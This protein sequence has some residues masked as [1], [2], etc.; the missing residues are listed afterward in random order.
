MQLLVLGHSHHYETANLCRVFF[1]LDPVKIFYEEAAADGGRRVVTRVSNGA[2][3]RFFVSVSDESGETVR[4]APCT[5]GDEEHALAAL[6]YTALAAHT[7]KSPKWGM[8]TGIHPIKLLRQYTREFGEAEGAARFQRENFVSAEKTA[9]ARETLCAEK[10][11]LEDIGENDFSLYI[12][13]PFCPTRCAYC[14]FVSQSVEQAKRQIPEYHALLLREIEETASVARALSLRLRTVYIGG[15]TPTTLSAKALLSLIQTVRGA[16][17]LSACTEFT[18]EAGRP[19]TID[20]EKLQALRAGGVTRISINPQTLDDRVLQAIGRRHTAEETVQAF[21]LAREEGFRNINMDLIV[22]LPEDT[23]ERFCS[24]IDRVLELDPESVTVHALA[25]KRSSGITKQG[26]TAAHGDTDL[27]DRMMAYAQRR[28]TAHGH[29][30]YY[31]Y[32][33]SRM[34]GNLENTGWAKPGFACAYNIYTMDE[35]ETVLAC[36]AGGVSKL[37]DPYSNNLERIFNFKY[38]YE[39]IS[40]YEEILK[41]KGGIEKHYE[42]FRKRIREVHQSSGADQ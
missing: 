2:A 15:G 30:P 32:R 22:G 6:L 14:S 35:S 8:L 11:F 19:D 31:L 16:F 42:Q 3:E 40:R 13:I 24:T 17:D 23:Y 41:R 5:A 36:G 26:V 29:V 34:A 39:Y 27:P 12:S 4:T 28:L 9:L 7:G 25:L 21:R 33:Q 37:V 1:P 38:S 20:R 18:V 10:P